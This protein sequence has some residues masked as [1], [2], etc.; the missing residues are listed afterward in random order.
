[1]SDAVRAAR[2]SSQN[3]QAYDLLIRADALRETTAAITD[4]KAKDV[5]LAMAAEY[6]ALAMALLLSPA[7]GG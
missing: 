3:E 4:W 2:P 1:M 6:E 5:L 7:H